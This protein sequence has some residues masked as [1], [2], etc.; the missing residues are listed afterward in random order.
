MV[1]GDHVSVSVEVDQQLKIAIAMTI[2][3]H[4]ARRNNL[5]YGVQVTI[6]LLAEGIHLMPFVQLR[7]ARQE[8]VSE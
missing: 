2:P 4:V 5:G 1:L 8:D 6:S 3:V 7:G